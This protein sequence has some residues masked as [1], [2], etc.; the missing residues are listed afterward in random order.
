MGLLRNTTFVCIDCETT[1]LDINKDKIIEIAMTKFTFEQIKDSFE[2]LIDPEMPIPLE[3]QK[4]H[5]ISQE[6]VSGKP[7]IKEFLE[8]T[9]D[10]AKNHPIVGHGISFD[11]DMICTAAEQLGLNC[12]LKKN[13]KIDTL[14]L[15]RLYGK[16]PSNSLETLR[17]HFNIDDEG[18]HRAMSDVIVNIKI[19]KQLA[20]GF[21]TKEDMLRRLQKPILLKTIPLGKH[22]GRSFDEI[23]LEYL[24]WAVKKD[25][26]ID[27]I[28]SIKKAIKKRK[29]KT[30]FGQ[31]SNP[32]FTL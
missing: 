28:Y 10:F 3:S 31:S 29:L 14:R 30:S 18:A 15:A 23:P 20:K 12:P 32:F 26:D 2:T 6:M 16:S 22:K 25:F 19:F 17:S 8:F 7:K 5:N 27:L 24:Y 21:V 4:I 13:I 1:G 11:I 9:F